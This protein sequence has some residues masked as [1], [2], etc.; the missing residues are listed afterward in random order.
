MSPFTIIAEPNRRQLL[1][2][3]LDGGKSVNT[4]VECIGMSQPVV[5][6]HLKIL[7][8]AGLVTVIPQG[9]R[10]LYR[11]NPDPLSEIESWLEPYRQFWDKKLD[12]LE[13]HL[14]EME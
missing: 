1:D 6:K 12:D 9:Q 7:R 3:L 13:Q 11:L 14:E 8:E 2:A 4:L 10:R 5:S